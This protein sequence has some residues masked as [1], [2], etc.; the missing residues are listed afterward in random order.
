ML[1]KKLR[2]RG[3]YVTR[4]DVLSMGFKEKKAYIEKIQAEEAVRRPLQ[5]EVWSAYTAL[6]IVH[7]GEEIF[8]QGDVSVDFVSEV[9]F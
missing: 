5:A 9:G 6:H 7:L 4:K 8:W 3:V 2:E 1:N